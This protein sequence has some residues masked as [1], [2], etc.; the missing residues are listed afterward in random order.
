[1]PHPLSTQLVA[2]YAAHQRRLPWRETRDPYHIWVAEI[3]LQ[4][5]Q[6]D[7]VIPY[8]QRW[9]KR[10]PTLRKLAAAPL[11]EVLACWE[12]LG[13]YARARH[14][15]RAAQQVVEE[16]GGQLPQTVAGLRALPGI[17][18]YTA[19]A[20]ASIAFGVDAAALDGNLKRVLARLFDVRQDIKS[21]AGDKTL[22]TLAESLVPP[23]QAGDYNQALMDLGATICL[24]RAPRCDVCPV[25]AMCEAYRLGVQLER[26]V[27][28]RRTPIP[29]RQ[30]AAG[31]VWKNGRLLLVQ[32]PADA[33]LGGLWAFPQVPRRGR[34]SFAGGL[35]RA[36]C[37]VWGLTVA[38]LAELPSQTQTFTH[39]RLA[40]HVFEC[41]WQSGRASGANCK[42]V[43]LS[44]LADY[45][46]GKSDRQIAQHLMAQHTAQR[47][48]QAK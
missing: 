2:W 34:E 20:V 38:V 13:Y 3:M 45:P 47:P 28:R 29:Q 24:P 16:A 25:Q 33:L 7:T 43:R 37:D 17:G 32:R 9:L 18:P 1:M 10:F 12:G 15:H 22:R 4:Q 44:A 40:L 5:T 39:F 27:S 31:V 46:M 35:A 30:A 8:Y 36:L 23:G 42:W 6:V 26:P 14:L 21:T 41:Q 19:A 11:E 48:A